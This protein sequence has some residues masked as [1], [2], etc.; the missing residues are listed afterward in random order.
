[1]MLWN[2]IKDKV[3]YKQPSTAENLRI[4]M[5]VWVTEI[6]REYSESLVSSMLRRIQA[7]FD[8]KRGHTKY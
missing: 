3:V 5:D 7:G 1:M 2:I 8:S 6:I 4:I